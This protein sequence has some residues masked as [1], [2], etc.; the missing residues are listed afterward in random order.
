MLKEFFG[1]LSFLMFVCAFAVPLLVLT[2]PA[3]GDDNYTITQPYTA[4]YT[5]PDGTLLYTR[6]G[7]SSNTSTVNHPADILEEYLHCYEEQWWPFDTV[8]ET[9]YRYVHASHGMTYV[10]NASRVY[11]YYDASPE[12]CR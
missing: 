6:T 3:V 12:A 4:Y 9:A 5:C 1:I 7:T 8:C 10:Y 11:Y 2:D